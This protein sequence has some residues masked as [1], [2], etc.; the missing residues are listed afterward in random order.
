M[1]STTASAFRD[2]N[3]TNFRGDL[4][5]YAH[6]QNFSLV[7]F[8]YFEFV[9][10]Q[11]D[12]VAGLWNFTRNVAEEAGNGGDRCIG[13]IAKLYAEQF[14]DIVDGHTAAHDQAA[15]GLP[16]HV[17]QRLLGIVTALADNF[18]HQI[19]HRGDPRY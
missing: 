10:F 16:N 18:F 8:Q 5:A 6:A 1:L 14:L 4:L 9:A 12:L 19:F 17:G 15:V 13:L 7:G 2:S 3:M 11:I